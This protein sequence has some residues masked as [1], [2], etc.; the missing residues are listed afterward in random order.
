MYLMCLMLSTLEVVDWLKWRRVEDERWQD[1]SDR[2]QLT[3]TLKLSTLTVIL[4]SF[5]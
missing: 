4:S 1:S 3:L 2:R 5:I